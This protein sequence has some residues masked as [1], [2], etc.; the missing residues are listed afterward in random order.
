MSSP[1]HPVEFRN[2]GG[3]FQFT[4]AT[5]ADLPAVLDLDP[6]LWAALSAPVS[7]LNAD[8]RF[9]G[10]LD[11]DKSGHI[12]VND[13]CS[14]IR[15]ITKYLQDFSPLSNE[16]TGL[17]V[18]AL[19]SDDADC[20]VILTF[21]DRLK[22][23]L[24]Q[25]GELQP[26]LVAK[27]LA[28]IAASPFKGDGV[29]T[30][31][32]VAGSNADTLYNAVLTNSGGTPSADGANKGITLAQLDKFKQDANDFLNWAA[33]AECPQFRE[34]DPVAPYDI[35]QKLIVKLDEYFNFCDLVKLEPSN[36][37][38]FQLDPAALP[39]LDL[40]DQAAVNSVLVQAPIT[41]P[42]AEGVLDFSG[43]LNPFYQGA[44]EKFAATF[45][46][47][48]LT[49]EQY[50]Q[51]KR[52]FAPY[53]DYLSKAKGNSIGALGKEKLEALMEDP[54]DA[55]L[56][57]LFARDSRQGGVLQSLRTLD[58]LCL[59]KQHLMNF[60]NNFV[61]FKALFS[62]DS[63]SLLQAGK[64][65]MDGHSYYLTMVIPNIA[66]HKAIAT[67]SNLCMLYLEMKP[68]PKQTGNPF[69]VAVAV[70]GGVLQRI[71]KGKPAYFIHNDGT[72]FCGKVVDVVDGPIS[73]WHTVFSPFRR[74][75]ALIGTRIQKFTD[76][77]AM[78]KQLETSVNTGKLPPVPAAA[79]TKGGLFSTNGS[80]F[81][82]AGG[83]SVAAVGAAFSFLAKSVVS[84]VESIS[85]MSLWTLIGGTL[86]IV[87]FIFVPIAINAILKMRKRN[88]TIFLEAAG[89]AV[90]LPMRLNASVSGLF[91][92]CG[93]YPEGTKFN[94]TEWVPKVR[95]FSWKAFLGWLVTGL[96]LAGLAFAYYLT[97]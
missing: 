63:R 32:A 14:A 88:L 31:A 27:K 54:A 76:F 91:T 26:A 71:Y 6:A 77:S 96:L 59:Y 28:E 65:V 21:V 35:F 42:N 3:S 19:N 55:V 51:I 13:V 79:P 74:L 72:H 89:W 49:K 38:R 1:K 66:A 70:T 97:H 17:P 30:P 43:N 85:K 11:S 7:S 82:L 81:L 52:D 57:D 10:Y 50:L 44:L 67:A 23:E 16:A 90:N 62:P 41:T 75:G 8:Q 48:T 15:F 83:L 78:E 60:V 69:F 94:R 93:I 40:A 84:I 33:T 24:V 20:S 12:C 80:I 56:R 36:L 47:E 86:A 46:L 29:L 61:S 37:K 2:I 4:A 87:L 68:G 22:D 9:L 92:R 18:A 53:A 64:L 45:Q 34:Q 73:F 95:S 5:P 58:M 25:N 39:P